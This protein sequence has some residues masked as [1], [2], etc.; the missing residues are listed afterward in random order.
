MFL[1]AF[2]TGLMTAA[3]HLSEQQVSPPSKEMLLQ[4]VSNTWESLRW[5]INKSIPIIS[6]VKVIHVD[7]ELV[8]LLVSTLTSL[9]ASRLM[10]MHQNVSEGLCILQ[11]VVTSALKV[12]SPLTSCP[13]TNCGVFLSDMKRHL[14]FLTHICAQPFRKLFQQGRRSFPF[15]RE[16]RFDTFQTFSHQRRKQ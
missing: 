13:H 4:S 7:L 16:A 6:G 11:K 8:F 15:H 2:Q 9:S 12:T 14:L 5:P 3:V 10:C 1:K